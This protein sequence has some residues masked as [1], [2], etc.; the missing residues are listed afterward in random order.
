MGSVGLEESHR[1]TK[2]RPMSHEGT[3][4]NIYSENSIK[5]V[6]FKNL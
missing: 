1:R 5:N 2:T 3:D 4:K 6:A